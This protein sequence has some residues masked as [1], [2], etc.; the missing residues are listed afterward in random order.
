VHFVA[1]ETH[2]PPASSR[3]RKTELREQRLESSRGGGAED[4]RFQITRVLHAEREGRAP[5]EGLGTLVGGMWMY[6]VV[7][8]AI[9]VTINVLIV[10]VVAV[11]ARHAQPR[12][13][14]CTELGA[15]IERY[16][17]RAA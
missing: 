7:A 5:S 1:C 2:S 10:L 17:R 9:L 16:V 13:E 12:E 4:R 14:L 3:T 15:K 8:A 6:L 11:L